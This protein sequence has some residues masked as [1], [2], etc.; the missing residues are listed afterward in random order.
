[1][2]HR[3]SGR[4]LG[5]TAPHR[6]ALYSNMTTS[7]IRHGR[8]KTTVTKA[9][10]LR[11][12]AEKTITWATSL[13]EILTSEKDKLSKEDQAKF[14]HHVRM[15]K[16]VVKDKEMLKKLF[17]EVGPQFLDRPGGYLRIIRTSGVRRGDAAPMAF[18]EL[19]IEEETGGTP[20][21]P[22]E[23]EE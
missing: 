14:V 3:K 20:E 8:I 18:V 12:V 11:R 22:Q 5:R 7:L 2:R 6:R 9:K 10:E 4:R 1:M 19:L 17:E 15:A 16:R 21:P 23:E 13:G